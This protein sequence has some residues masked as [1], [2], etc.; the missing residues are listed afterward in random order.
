MFIPAFV[1]EWRGNFP[2]KRVHD[3]V[4]GDY[5]TLNTNRMF[6]ITEAYDGNPTMFFF[7][8]PANVKD[9][10]AR[11]KITDE[12]IASI[13]AYAD[14]DHGSDS[15]TLDVF[16]EN[17]P[18]LA[19]YEL[20]LRKENIAYI[21]PVGGTTGASWLVYADMAWNM[22]RVLVNKDYGD[23]WLELNGDDLN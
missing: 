6:E 20:T 14:T 3:P 23:L 21:Y 13:I 2:E 17:N 10:G 1:L 19:T 12:S 9:G 8:N 7:D 18:L 16:P 11:L 5:Y 4:H 22:I 15:I